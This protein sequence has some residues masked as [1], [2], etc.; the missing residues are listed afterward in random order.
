MS[1]PEW[2]RRQ[3]EEAAA[4]ARYEEEEY[5]RKQKDREQRERQ[6]QDDHNRSVQERD[7]AAQEQQRRA[8]QA[9]ETSCFPGSTMV[10]VPGGERAIADIC[11]G[12]Y[13]LSVSRRR[14]GFSEV[15]VRKRVD[16][17]EAELWRIEFNEGQGRAS[18]VET[19]AVH[20]FLTSRGWIRTTAL[21]VGDYLYAPAGSSIVTNI[22]RSLDRRPVYNLLLNSH[23]TFIASGVIVHSFSYFRWLRGGWGTILGL[24]QPTASRENVRVGV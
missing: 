19:T 13:V 4:K 9:S 12:D 14:A 17:G 10:A 3:R 21:R 1:E 16:H 11:P 2:A 23:H 15:C 7:R 20:S 24:M 18:A 8:A 22:Q 6:R 5:Q